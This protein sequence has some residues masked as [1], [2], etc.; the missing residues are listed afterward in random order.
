MPWVAVVAQTEAALQAEIQEALQAELDPEARMWLYGDHVKS[1]Y[2]MG[3]MVAAEAYAD[4]AI[5]LATQLEADSAL[6]VFQNRRGLVRYRTGQYE[7]A[8]KDL[9]TAVA[10][11]E[12]I[13]DSSHVSGTLRGVALVYDAQGKYDL[14]LEVHQRT[15]ML[16]RALQ[17]TLMEAYALNNIGNVY[18]SLG[19]L[20]TGLRYYQD[21]LAIYYDQ[22]DTASIL[23]SYINIGNVYG[24]QGDL[25]AAL[26][27]YCKAHELSQV[28]GDKLYGVYAEESVGSALAGLGRYQAAE[29][30]LLTA[31]RQ[32]AEMNNQTGL[33]RIL[34]NL[35]DVYQQRD[36]LPKARQ[37]MEEA[38]RIGRQ[39]GA[40][41][42]IQVALLGLGQIHLKQHQPQSARVYL[43]EALQLAQQN[44]ALFD[45]SQ[46]A[47]WLAITDSALGDWPRAWA[48]FKLHVQYR[49]SVFNQE[50]AKELGRMESRFEL[51]NERREAELAAQLAEQKEAARIARRNRLQYLGLGGAV[52]VLMLVVLT[53]GRRRFA[54]RIA[55][56]LT[57][58]S[59]LML[60]E[61]VLVLLDPL[62]ESRASE[63]VYKLGL[64]VLLAL[65]I[66]PLHHWLE[67]K[68]RPLPAKLDR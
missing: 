47:K 57:F 3:Y 44:K 36:E 15:L 2:P 66:T 38:L 7:A 58:V 18:Y 64:N 41:E 65:L 53:W 45:L 14:A 5:T 68:T 56:A 37:T 10:T 62:L 63:P 33:G 25:E 43:S 6:A 67:Q 50:K 52:A 26:V 4:T 35:A 23:S 32:Y 49:D 30:H 24:K 39:I 8:L 61:F 59:Y 1:L 13:G 20:H 22:H 51:E 34:I 28:F 31:Q 11:F 40:A 9:H 42:N 17:D 55:S 19:D 54:P 21:A 46:A 29:G 60:F 27:Q 48:N 12:A 16:E